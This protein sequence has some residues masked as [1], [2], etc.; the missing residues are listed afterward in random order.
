MDT[1]QAE[2]QRTQMAFG[3]TEPMAPTVPTY[4]PSTSNEARV[5][6]RLL[7]MADAYR[8]ENALR[9]AVAIYFTLVE[10]YEDSP[11]AAQAFDRLMEI[12]EQHER[13]GEPRNARGIY[14]RLL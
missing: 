13:A 2:L 7:E 11:E 5:L 1:S 9:Q 8:G 12:A 4:Q 3:E 14:D 10:K 6:A